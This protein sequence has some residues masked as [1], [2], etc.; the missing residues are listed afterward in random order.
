MMNKTLIL[1]T[2]FSVA[3]FAQVPKSDSVS[4]FSYSTIAELSTQLNEI[5]DDPNFGNAHWGVAIQSLETGEYFYR[6]NENKLF[7]PASNLK[8]F[9]TAAGLLILGKDYTFKTELLT[10]G[11]VDGSV[12]KGNLIVKGYGDPSISGRFYGE[13]NLEIFRSWADSLLEL[14]IDEIRGN[15]IGDDDNFDDIGLGDGWSWDYESYWYSAPTGAL[16]FNDNCVDLI[17][18]PTDIGERAEIKA[19][20]SSRYAVIVNNVFTVPDDSLTSIDLYRDRGTNI[21]TVSGSVK[22]SNQTIKAYATINNP[23][24][25]FVITLK[26]VLEEKGIKVTGFALDIDDLD[27]P[28]SQKD[29]HLLLTHRSVPLNEIVKIIN[30]NSHNFYAE[31]LLKTLGLDKSKKGTA[32]H[33]IAAEKNL[34]SQMGIIPESIILADG[35]GLSRLNYVS[36]QHILTLLNHMYK[37]PVFEDFYSSLP[38]AGKNGTLAK[39]MIRTNAQ[40]NVRAKTGFI[41]NVRSLSGYM[42]TGDNELL[43]FTMIAN[44]FNVPFVLA[45]NIQDLVC[46]RLANFKR[47]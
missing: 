33:G 4:R 36:P 30:K 15:I 3:V 10:D 47:K 34:F 8:L 40:D 7:M 28:L 26:E 24:Q 12:L 39:R 38:V 19:L 25:Y 43:S 21:I 42:R 44:N 11:N 23:T 20:P 31:Q 17:I 16:S 27:K 45:E 29:F 1:L 2:L 35:S 9:T 13:D 32:A 22:Y 46:T 41:G 6:R 37:S 5:F 18:N 14:G